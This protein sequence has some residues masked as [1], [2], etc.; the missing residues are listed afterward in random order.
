MS[1]INVLLIVGSRDSSVS[2]T[3]AEF[4]G[5][6]SSAGIR[7]RVFDSLDELPPFSE[8]AATVELP[9]SVDALR[10]AAAAADAVLLVTPYYASVP[11]S[12]HN[13][14]DWLAMRWT[15]SELHE[16]PL[17]VM[18]YSADCYRGVW[19]HRESGQRRQISESRIIEP[20]TVRS[21]E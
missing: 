11:A 1:G 6:S 20:I 3:L 16:K 14:I 13:A 4:A 8:T 21:E 5:E 19:S 9:V 17:A 15:D 10:N 7:L 12:V 2:G 18:G